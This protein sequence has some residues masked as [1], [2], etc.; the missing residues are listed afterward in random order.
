MQCNEFLIKTGISHGR[1]SEFG[2]QEFGDQEFGVIGLRRLNDS[3]LI[4]ILIIRLIS[5][6]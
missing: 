5:E 1:E 4:R 3:I 2:D 6:Y